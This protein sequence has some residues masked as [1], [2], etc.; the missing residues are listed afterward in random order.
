MNTY[1]E[2]L[3]TSIVN[4]LDEQAA[5]L[6]KTHSAL[7]AQEISLYYSQGALISANDKFDDTLQMYEIQQDILASVNENNNSAINVVD[8]ATQEKT[9]VDQAVNNSAVAA[10]NVQI[11]ANAIVHLAGDIGN[12]FSIVSAADYKSQIYDQTEEAK[13]NMDTTAYNAKL[14]SQY[15]MESTMLTS[16]ITASTVLT[17]AQATGVAL[18]SLNDSFKAQFDKTSATLDAQNTA[19][20]TANNLE[21]KAEGLTEDLNTANY[22]TRSAYELNN[23]ELNS[24]L[25]VLVNHGDD[26]TPS[27]TD[28]FFN[29]EFSPYITPLYLDSK[30]DAIDAVQQYYIIIVDSSSKSTF[31]STSA[32][33]A[34]SGSPKNGKNMYVEVNKGDISPNNPRLFGKKVEIANIA[35]SNGLDIALGK[36]YCLFLYIKMTEK[37]KKTI[38][39]YSDILS[40]G[41][42]SFDLTHQLNA[43]DFLPTTGGSKV[44]ETIVSDDQLEFQ[45]T[46]TIDFNMEYRVMFIPTSKD[47]V[48]NLLSDANLPTVKERNKYNRR[49]QH[50]T[51]RMASLQA[52]ID[53]VKS[54]A[55]GLIDKITVKINLEKD[56]YFNATT[57]K[58]K[59]KIQEGIDLLS[60]ELKIITNTR[61][62]KVTAL[63]ASIVESS[64]ALDAVEKKKETE[65][66]THAAKG[67]FFNL[68]L[69]EQ[70]PT[71]LYS[72]A[73]NEA[74]PE[75]ATGKFKVT[76]NEDTTDNYGNKLNNKETYVPVILSYSKAKASESAQY[77]NALSDFETTTSF[78]FLLIKPSK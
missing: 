20:V 37:Y 55:G 47:K 19:V 16:S 39:N 56:R 11:A 25:K 15:A 13:N 10:S 31:S 75:S 41:S 53:N 43:V 8:A 42:E 62:T 78:E 17:E 3:R 58:A 32:D 45:A 22:G 51:S 48:G 21:K 4:S 74:N 57:E 29:L 64:T 73:T 30:G 36:E 2:N 40:A 63:E 68:A 77:S 76:L 44:P 70:V 12:V 28:K 9:Y 5:S 46:Q 67:V 1:N 49:I 72:P 35:D 34:I 38:N 24:G 71:G 27:K 14:A 23:D 6:Q 66:Q 33:T 7:G 59:A 52:Q 65:A 60:S 50:F 18:Q 69:A 61:D 54:K 26:A